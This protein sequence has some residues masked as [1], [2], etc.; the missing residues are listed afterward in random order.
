M[1]EAGCIVWVAGFITLTSVFVYA[2][3]W[4]IANPWKDHDLAIV[5]CSIG[6]LLSFIGVLVFLSKVV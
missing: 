2:V 5:F 1:S 3:L 4:N 6:A